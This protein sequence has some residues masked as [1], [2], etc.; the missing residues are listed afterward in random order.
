MH[1]LAEM[2]K[3][4]Q[5][6]TEAKEHD[7]VECLVYSKEQSVIML[8]TLVDEAEES[9]VIC[10]KKTSFRFESRISYL[11]RKTYGCY[12]FPWMEQTINKIKAFEVSSNMDLVTIPAD[13]KTLRG[14][15]G[16]LP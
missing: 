2:S 16:V 15:G 14:G 7:F 6:L 10:H 9:K 12:L 13:S 4:F 8:G 11:L 1:R 5:K 3:R